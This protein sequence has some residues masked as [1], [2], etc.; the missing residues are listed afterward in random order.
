MATAFKRFP[1][2]SQSFVAERCVENS[3]ILVTRID[4]NGPFT[5]SEFNTFF[6][7]QPTDTLYLFFL[8]LFFIITLF[9][10]IYIYISMHKVVETNYTGIR[11]YI[12]IKFHFPE[13]YASSEDFL[14]KWGNSVGSLVKFSMRMRLDDSW[15]VFNFLTNPR[16][17]FHQRTNDYI[18]PLIEDN[19]RRL[20]LTEAACHLLVN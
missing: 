18:E 7:L 17:F 3:C 11:E 12:S 2:N 10:G 14:S 1:E 4:T 5:R 9:K 15:N 6:T 8:L 20:L 13:N 16:S 19:R